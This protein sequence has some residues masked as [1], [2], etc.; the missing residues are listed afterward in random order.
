MPPLRTN[1]SGLF[2]MIDRY[3]RERLS[4]AAKVLVEMSSHS[5]VLG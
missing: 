4:G 5:Y 1:A 2:M 3:L